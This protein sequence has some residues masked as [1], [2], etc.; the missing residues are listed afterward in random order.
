MAI[1]LVCC[2]LQN[3]TMEYHGL[4]GVHNSHPS[5]PPD[6]LDDFLADLRSN[7]T[8]AFDLNGLSPD[9]ALASGGQMLIYTSA[10]QYHHVNDADFVCS[11][12]QAGMILRTAVRQKSTI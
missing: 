9:H 3:T 7:P 2:L 10:M 1:L 5:A 12:E 11:F 8:L 6:T 4:S